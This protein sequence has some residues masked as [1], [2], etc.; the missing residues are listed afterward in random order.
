MKN[1]FQRSLLFATLLTFLASAQSAYAYSQYSHSYTPVKYTFYATA[2][3]SGETQGTPTFTGSSAITATLDL[4]NQSFCYRVTGNGIPQHARGVIAQ[5]TVGNS[6][7]RLIP[8]ST[9][10]FG[11]KHITCV[12]SQ[13]AI[14][15]SF[16]NN[17]GNYYY[18]LQLGK[19]NISGIRG[20]FHR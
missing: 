13:T 19:N 10:E 17:P 1:L 4:V 9:M 20:Q 14:L 3:S 7:K 5:G 11:S 18:E 6:G 12:G 16:V 2:T 15:Q 8:I